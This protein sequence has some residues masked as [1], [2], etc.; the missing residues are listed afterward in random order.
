MLKPFYNK[1]KN[2]DN[3]LLPAATAVDAGKVVGVTEDGKISLV[4]GD[5]IGSQGPF[6]IES[7]PLSGGMTEN[8]VFE[9]EEAAIAYLDKLVSADR[10]ILQFT[11]DTTNP[12]NDPIIANFISAQAKITLHNNLSFS[13]E[14]SSVAFFVAILPSSSVMFQATPSILA[15]SKTVHIAV[16]LIPAE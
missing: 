16:D 7:L 11:P 13:I 10:I 2:I 12:D 8:I 14:G 6:N 5:G 3:R 9:S 4:E 15:E 1:K